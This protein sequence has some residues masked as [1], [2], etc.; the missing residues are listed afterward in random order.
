M[1]ERTKRTLFRICFLL[2]VSKVEPKLD[3][4]TG[5]SSDQNVPAMAQQHYPQVVA[6][7]DFNQAIFTVVNPEGQ[8]CSLCSTAKAFLF[9]RPKKGCCQVQIGICQQEFEVNI[10]DKYKT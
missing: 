9:L 7:F 1:L 2:P 10:R 4:E 6:D 5:S 3:H 8:K